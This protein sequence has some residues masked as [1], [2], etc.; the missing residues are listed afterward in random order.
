VSN[1][2]V[3]HHEH[4]QIVEVAALPEVEAELVVAKLKSAGIDA[5]TSGDDQNG[6]RPSLSYADG[7]RVMV[8]EKDVAAAQQIIAD[9]EELDK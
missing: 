7:Y 9:T 4:E 2:G 5:Y 6:L 1:D 3:N 8:F